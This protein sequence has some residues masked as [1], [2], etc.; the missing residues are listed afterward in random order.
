MFDKNLGIFLECFLNKMQKRN[1]PSFD[2]E[3]Y[4]LNISCWLNQTLFYRAG[5]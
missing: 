2:L 5:W 1:S 4:I 3:I